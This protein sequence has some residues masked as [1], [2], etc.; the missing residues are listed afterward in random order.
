MRGVPVRQPRHD[1]VQI[2][3]RRR[4]R[5]ERLLEHAIG[6]V[7]A[8]SGAEIGRPDHR[9][10]ALA[11]LAGD[12]ELHRR[13]R[14]G[15]Q[16]NCFRPRVDAHRHRQEGALGLSAIEAGR[17][18]KH[19]SVDKAAH[20]RQRR[21]LPA[22]DLLGRPPRVG[23]AFFATKW[24][25]DSFVSNDVAPV[26]AMHLESED[27]LLGR[28]LPVDIALFVR[29]GGDLHL[30]LAAVQTGNRLEKVFEHVAHR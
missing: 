6:A 27:A 9:D 1:R 21:L 25:P 24:A 19:R 16:R 22:F 18:A 14:R 23:I 5:A 2:V 4:D 15:R 7:M 13:G 12:L 10:A 3:K 20:L 29:L 26:L 11:R 17:V 30:D 8:A 28:A